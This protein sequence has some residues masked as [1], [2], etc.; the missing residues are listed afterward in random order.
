[1]AE[2][3]DIYFQLRK[4]IIDHEFEPG[5]KLNQRV[6]AESFGISSTPVIKVLHRL[7]SEGLVDN[8]TNRGFVVHSSN[9]KE[10]EDLYELRE[11]LEVTAVADLAELSKAETARIA[12]ELQAIF[13]ESDVADEIQYRKMDVAFH[14]HII[15]SCSNDM[16]KSINETHQILNRTY[17]PGLLRGP[18]ATYAEH[19]RIID[20]LRRRD[21]DELMQA[22]R[23]H[24]SVTKQTISKLVKRLEWIGLNPRTILVNDLANREFDEDNIF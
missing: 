15:N 23:E 24:I 3:N 16:L 1:M 20:A 18:S 22:M 11:A 19:Q 9:V 10:L 7:T 14:N 6:L 17:L 5:Q 12:D 8:I 2:I 4:Q 21:K 13:K